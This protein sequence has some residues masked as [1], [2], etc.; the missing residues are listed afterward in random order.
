MGTGFGFPGKGTRGRSRPDQSTEK[1][2]ITWCPT[3]GWVAVCRGQRTPGS[4]MRTSLG[5]WR[6]AAGS[7]SSRLWPRLQRRSPGAARRLVGTHLVSQPSSLA[8]LPAPHKSSAS[9]GPHL[10][11]PLPSSHPDHSGDMKPQG[12]ALTP[13]RISAPRSLH[14]GFT[15]PIRCKQRGHLLCL[16]SLRL[17]Q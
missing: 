11:K 17:L 15:L 6:G 13:P 7:P 4:G 2:H 14:L 1:P 16:S 8:A 5:S 3:P 12:L 10:C 9:W